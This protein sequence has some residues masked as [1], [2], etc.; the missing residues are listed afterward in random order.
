MVSAPYWF[1]ARHQLLALSHERNYAAWWS[2]MC[3]FMAALLFYRLA[4]QQSI[5][6][7]DRFMWATLAMIMAGLSLDEIGSL[8]ERLSQIGGWWMLAPFALV[9][10]SMTLYTCWRLVVV[11]Q[12]RATAYLVLT[13]LSIFVGVAGLEFIEHNVYIP[14]YWSHARAVG[15]E[16]VELVGMFL[17]ILAGYRQLSLQMNGP[18]IS[19]LE[20]MHINSLQFAT[21]LL[22][23]GL[24]VQ[25]AL[26]FSMVIGPATTGRGSPLSW[27]P[28]AV[29]LAGAVMCLHQGNCPNEL[30]RRLFWWLA[31]LIF[32]LAS[33]GQ[34]VNHSKFLS[35][36]S[37][38]FKSNLYR[39]EMAN[40]LWLV[41]PTV[42]VTL[43]LTG[44]R[45]LGYMALI[46]LSFIFFYAETPPSNVYYV[47]SSIVAVA[48]VKC[49]SEVVAV[50]NSVTN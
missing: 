42:V 13:G 5:S 17:F 15:E 28:S 8:H 27:F 37:E 20:N 3:L 12:H 18:R 36:L 47:M 33:M 2:G 9:G 22:F 6:N 21:H 39:A 14:S 38:S 34:L 32:L 11:P 25:V 26:M 49:L 30:V 29:F 7:K 23:L 43:L 16:S 4:S 41:A 48:L 1:Y 10:I 35:L 45:G 50:V 31:G 46:V 24:V 40:I 44:K 19:L